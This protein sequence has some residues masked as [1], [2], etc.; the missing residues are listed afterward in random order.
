MVRPFAFGY[1]PETA[2][3]NA[4]QHKPSKND[5]TKSYSDIALEEFDDS[6]ATLQSFG[7]KIT[8]FNEE[9]SA[10]KKPDSVFP[11]N[12]F[13]THQNG[14]IILYPMLAKSRRLEKR[15]DIVHYLQHNFGVT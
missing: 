13:S 9:P 11:N 7:V 1:D 10:I 2:I 5:K 12:W 15:Q 4:F 8:I 6:V 14:T 3:S